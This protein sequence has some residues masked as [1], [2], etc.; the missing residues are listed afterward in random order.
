MSQPLTRKDIVAE[1][2]LGRSWGWRGNTIYVL[3]EVISQ[4]DF[5]KCKYINMDIFI[6]TLH[7]L[8][9]YAFCENMNLIWIF[10]IKHYR[11]YCFQ[12]D[13][14]HINNLFSI[15]WNLECFANLILKCIKVQSSQINS[16]SL[17][18]FCWILFQL[19]KEKVSLQA[20]S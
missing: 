14:H 8:L 13:K 1:V 15:F 17:L 4:S 19:D 5:H 11:F 18:K 9:G 6:Y 16:V 2:S 12:S 10:I 3:S 7:W 20:V